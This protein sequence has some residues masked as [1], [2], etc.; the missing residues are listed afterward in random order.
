VLKKGFLG[1]PGWAKKKWGMAPFARPQGG[2]GPLFKIFGKGKREGEAGPNS[3]EAGRG[4]QNGGK[5]PHWEYPGDRK[6]N[7]SKKKSKLKRV[8][9][10]RG[11]KVIDKVN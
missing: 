6:S 9:S 7:I 5:K 3:S 1:P 8:E 10:R 4:P 11:Q 2:I